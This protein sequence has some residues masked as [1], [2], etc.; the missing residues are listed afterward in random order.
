MATRGGIASWTFLF[1][2]ASSRVTPGR[3]SPEGSFSSSSL[4]SSSCIFR[5]LISRFRS[6]CSMR[7]FIRLPRMFLR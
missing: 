5:G 4:A 6:E 3:G 1:A 2:V 7:L